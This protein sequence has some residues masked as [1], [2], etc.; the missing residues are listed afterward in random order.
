MTRLPRMDAHL[1][2]CQATLKRLRLSQGDSIVSD[3]SF[4]Y[5]LYLREIYQQ[6][7]L[8]RYVSFTT[9]KNAPGEW[10]LTLGQYD[11]A[12]IMESGF[13]PLLPAQV[14]LRLE[15]EAQWRKQGVWDESLRLTHA[16]PSDT[17][18]GSDVD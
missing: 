1:R 16:C 17:P 15:L 14:R 11:A 9:F 3:E 5:R 12:L 13:R 7:Y 18:S 10:L 2:R 8:N 4:L 6:A